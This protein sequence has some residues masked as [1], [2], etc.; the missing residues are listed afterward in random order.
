VVAPVTSLVLA[1]RGD[2]LLVSTLD[3][4]LRLLD[5]ADGKMLKMYAHGDYVNTTYRIR[6]T[7]VGRGD[8]FVL[9]GSEDGSIFAWETMGGGMV[10][11]LWHGSEAS[12]GEEKG[13]RRVVSAI[14]CRGGR[15]D[16]WASAGGDGM[17]AR[18]DGSGEMS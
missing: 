5:R 14:A 7:L 15:R 6:A 3:S 1:S 11:R 12:G 10:K 4:T 18:C 2:S 8:G 17:F 16:E 9:A 13:S